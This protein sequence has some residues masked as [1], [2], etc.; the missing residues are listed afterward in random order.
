MPEQAKILFANEAFYVAIANRDG[1]AMAAL[2]ARD[3]EVTCLH[4]GWPPIS[5][6]EDVTESWQRILSN[7]DQ[8]PIDFSNATVQ[9]I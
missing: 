3:V 8:P 9:Q 2:W 6:H 1:G 4:P 7:E 5:G